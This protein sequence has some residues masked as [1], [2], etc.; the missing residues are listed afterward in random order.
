ME[1]KWKPRSSHDLSVAKSAKNR[2]TINRVAAFLRPPSD[3][4]RSRLPSDVEAMQGEKP[5]TTHYF[6]I[7]SPDG[8]TRSQAIFW[9]T[10]AS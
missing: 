4:D 3:V 2:G 5:F 7:L 6:G 10:T 9:N 8:K 1:R